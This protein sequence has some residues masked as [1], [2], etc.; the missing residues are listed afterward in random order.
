MMRSKSPHKFLALIAI[1]FGMMF[2]TF[3]LP[4]Y[5][6]ECD[7]SWFNPWAQ[8]SSE[9]AQ[10]SQAKAPK[11]QHSQNQAKAKS[12]S[13]SSQSAKVRGKNSAKRSS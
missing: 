7:P 4:A 3:M 1:S 11:S 10:A 8:S 2:G 6:Q 13:A 12:A 5:G 9:S